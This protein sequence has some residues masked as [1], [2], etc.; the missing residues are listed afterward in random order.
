METKAIKYEAKNIDGQWYMTGDGLMIK[1]KNQEYA[2]TL[3]R[4]FP[5]IE[6]TDPNFTPGRR[7]KSV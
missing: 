7:K 1:V 6:I 3:A 4:I 5:T 2:E